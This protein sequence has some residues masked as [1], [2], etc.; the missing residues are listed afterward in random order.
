[1]ANQW[2]R[3]WHDMPNDPKWRTI[4]RVACQPIALAQSVYL[5]LLVSA[6]QNVTRGH[7]DVTLED[8]A[9]A[10]DVTEAEISAILDAMQGRVLDGFYITGWEKRQPKREDSGDTENGAKSAA[11]RKR[12]QREREK[13]AG[14]SS[15]ENNDVTH[16]HEESHKVTLDKDK[17]KDKD[18]DIKNNTLVISEKP[19]A[20]KQTFKNWLAEIV[21]SDQVPIPET[22]SIF[23]YAEQAN[24][25]TE[26]LELAWIEFKAKYSG[27]PKLYTDWPAV[28]SNAVRENWLKLWWINDNGN[29]VLSATG[30]QALLVKNNESRRAA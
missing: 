12:A 29:Y 7:A 30:K 19:K 14:E 9:S 10:L 4:S 25:P 20:K 17:D 27:R 18:K 26:F 21:K 3:L 23:K 8:L 1:M 2:L 11:E 6:S 24:I 22:H 28:F 15:L 5:H 13:L 16:S